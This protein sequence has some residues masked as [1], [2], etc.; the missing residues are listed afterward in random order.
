MAHN[1]SVGDERVDSKPSSSGDTARLPSVEDVPFNRDHGHGSFGL[2]PAPSRRVT[3]KPVVKTEARKRKSAGGHFRDFAWEVVK[4]FA[5]VLILRA[6]VVQAST[7][8]GQSMEPNLFDK[9]YLLVERLTV[10]LSGLPDFLLEVLP[11]NWR[12][13]IRRGDLVVLSSPENSNNELVKRVIAVAGDRMFFSGG[14]I[15]I[16]GEAIEESYLPRDWLEKLGTNHEGEIRHYFESDVVSMPHQY[17][18]SSD[19]LDRADTPEQRLRLGVEI[20]E[21]CIFVLGDNR[22]SSKDSRA[23]TRTRINSDSP[24]R[25]ANGT[26]HLWAT[27]RS[28]HGRVFM[29]LRLPWQY[30]E[31]HPVFPR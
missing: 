10:S 16:N 17:V 31:Q 19:Q 23:W 4:I 15:Y 21:G 30:D 3:E 29:R 18:V 20:P 28:V 24:G 5:I 12:P 9:D 26:N 14:K 11:E 25:S 22:Q 7:V 8:D 1:P 13:R 2:E 6:Y 27:V